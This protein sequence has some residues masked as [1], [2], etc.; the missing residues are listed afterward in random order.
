MLFRSFST[1]EYAI[2][3]MVFRSLKIADELASSAIV[4]GIESPYKKD[5]YYITRLTVKDAL[6]VISSIII[7][8]ICC[9]V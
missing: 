6:L 2:V 5:S 3:P 4:R 1:L 7:A 8:V 9:L